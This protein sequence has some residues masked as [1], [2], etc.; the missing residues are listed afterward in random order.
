MNARIIFTIVA[1]VLLPVTLFAATDCKIVE[2]SD[3]YEAICVGD[4]KYLPEMYR[5]GPETQ[6]IPKLRSVVP[7]AV[8]KSS[9][10][11][12]IDNE[13]PQAQP[14]AVK[15][16]IAFRQHKLQRS[17]VDAKRLVR[18]QMIKAGMQNQIAMPQPQVSEDQ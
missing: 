17:D 16:L 13:H 4:E 3:H 2:L 1:T 15:Q 7:T 11:G 9:A 5:G 10:V 18:M 8:P 14:D 12:K 6:N